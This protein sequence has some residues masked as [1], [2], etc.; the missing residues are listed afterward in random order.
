MTIELTPTEPQG[1]VSLQLIDKDGN[2]VNEVINLVPVYTTVPIKVVEFGP[3]PSSAIP[4]G[5]KTNEW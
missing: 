3:A 1:V 2:P 4:L 5:W